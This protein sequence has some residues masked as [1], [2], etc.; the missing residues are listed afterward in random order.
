MKEAFLITTFYKFQVIPEFALEPLRERLLVEGKRLDICGLLLIGKEGCNATIAGKEAALNEYK[1][2][3]MAQPE[4]GSLE[5]KDSKSISKPFRRFKIDIRKEIVTIKDQA[6]IPEKPKNNHLSPKEWQ[7]VLDSNEKVF[8]VDTRNF[9]ETEVGMFRGA[10]DLKLR[11]FSDFPEKMRSLD[12]PK[13]SKVLMYCTGG[14]RCEKAIV[15]LQRAGYSNVFQ[16]EGGILKY[17]EEFPN[18][19]FEGECFVFDHRV[20]VDQNLNPS[21]VYTFCPHCGNPAKTDIN[22]ALCEKSAVVCDLCL[23][24]EDLR[25]CSKNCAHHYRRKSDSVSL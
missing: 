15:D 10:V 7:E 3:L 6:V 14:I 4:I 13:E 24:N 19:D 5:W 21:S 2:F 20:S 1:E 9:Y 18:K 17:L 11:K 23:Q 16:L 22:C 25:T 8:M 12:V